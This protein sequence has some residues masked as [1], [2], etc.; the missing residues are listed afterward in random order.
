MSINEKWRWVP[1]HDLEIFSEQGTA[2]SIA[3]RHGISDTMVLKIKKDECWGN[4]TCRSI[5]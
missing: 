5:G 3:R 1:G 4:V 2:A